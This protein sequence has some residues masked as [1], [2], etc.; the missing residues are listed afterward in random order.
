MIVRRIAMSGSAI[1][2]D[3][4]PD[5][6]A[7]QK[8]TPMMGQWSACKSAAGNALLLFRMGDFYEAFY[9]DAVTL[10]RELDLTLTKRQE[11]PMAGVPHHTC[12]NYID[13]LVAKGFRVA[14]AEQTE[15]P[16]KAKGLVKREV[17]RVVTPGTV[18]NSTL[19][20]DNSNNFIASVAQVGKLFGIAFLDLTTADFRTIE[21][22]SEEELLNELCRLQPSE[23][24][25]TQRL[26]DKLQP[27]LSD[28]RQSFTFVVTSHNDWRF[29]HQSAH[30]FLTTH[31]GV[32]SL[33]GYGLGGMVTAI[34][35]AG[36]LLSYIQD[37][38]CLPISHIRGIAP[39]STSTYMAIDRSTQRHLELTESLSDRSVRG[40]LLSILDKTRT[41]MGARLMRQWIKHPLTDP[42]AIN[43]RLD[44]VESFISHPTALNH[45]SSSLENVRDL[46]RLIMRVC[47]GYATPRDLIALKNS[48]EPIPRIK[49]SLRG[50]KDRSS[51]L[52]QEDELIEPL[53]EMIALIQNALND[54]PP[55][56]VSDGKVIRDGYHRELDELR[57]ISRD[58]K[59]WLA[60]Y[61]EQ[62]KE[63]T[64]IK[65]LKVG[66][67]KM[68]GY[69]IEV[70]KG[71]TDK[72][73]ESFNRRQTL[74]N[75]ERYI[76][77]EL[78]EYENKVM[79]AEDK[80]A[81]IEAEL[82]ADI[83]SRV[84]S[85]GQYVQRTAQALAKVD[86]LHALA[87]TATAHHYVRPIIDD[88]SVLEIVSGRHP[89]IEAVHCEEKF[90]PNDTLLDDSE[91]R[92]L[93]I[94]GPNMAG[95]STY[96]RQVALI[97][98]MAHMGSFVPA[99][100]ARIGIVDKVFSRIGA[101]DDLSRGQSTFMVEMMET[102]NILNNA[103]SRSLVILDEIGRGTSTYDG[104][105]IAWSVAE[106]LLTA[107]NRMAKTLFATHYWE[108]T[109]LE[110]KVPGAKNYNVAVHEA[111]DSII[112]LRK[113]VRGG[114]DRSYGIHVGRLAGLPAAVIERAKEIL[115]HLEEN[116]NRKSAFEPAQP[117]RPQ[118]RP[119]AKIA[120]AD[121][122]LTLFN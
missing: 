106:H 104:I 102:A 110:E 94:T 57:E 74:V 75:A 76:T 92:M 37:I 117:K 62:L 70:S 29:D 9:D 82:F 41:P 50:V 72:M 28:M 121:M 51:F 15:D 22:T 98:I 67:N 87:L 77:P 39:Y 105:S 91:N 113:I 1:D 40:T 69:Y 45:L 49:S 56:R 66:F 95:K 48:Y 68:F 116:A 101:S 5:T 10:A 100:S 2:E 13:R 42:R 23:I 25:L 71:Q 4:H 122:Q 63:S 3:L 44:A 11:I 73:P 79:H 81:A 26:S 111:E 97:A 78:K 86:V 12:E 27:L 6:A 61:Q 53:P 31:F 99:A 103:T 52:K 119:K 108:L 18:I 8:T 85:Y 115:V 33:D 35:A 14:I 46:E 59:S 16:R 55:L 20:S 120:V 43:Q 19:L 24:V 89:V 90:V 60:R 34:N 58:S 47:S 38:L 107:E 114:T 65:T 83:R 93:L 109:K 7:E 17:V 118:T 30:D 96:I 88:T 112:F 84:A 64:G 54:D 36:G 32:R 21:L 80:I